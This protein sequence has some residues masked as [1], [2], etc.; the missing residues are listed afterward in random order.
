MQGKLLLFFRF[1]KGELIGHSYEILIH[2]D[3][4]IKERIKILK[5]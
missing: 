1:S 3:M 4:K 2:K 5:Y